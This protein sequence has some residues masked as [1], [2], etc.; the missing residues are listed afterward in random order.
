M[1][2]IEKSTV[3][4][5]CQKLSEESSVI[6]DLP[7]DGMM[8]I[9]KLLPY[10]CVYRYKK[11]DPR[12]A[13]LL[14]TQASYLIV[15]E[16]VAITHLLEAVSKTVSEKLNAFLILELWPVRQDHG[17]EFEIYCPED[18]APATVAERGS[19]ARDAAAGGYFVMRGPR[20]WACLPSGSPITES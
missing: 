12:F 16:N 17:A 2:M 13:G 5:V 7:H 6:Q 11:A 1:I 14:K 18:K 15:E 20:S 19:R 4:N 10:I 9:E 8:Y 3:R